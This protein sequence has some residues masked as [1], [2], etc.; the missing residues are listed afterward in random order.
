MDGHL[1]SAVINTVRSIGVLEGDVSS[2]GFLKYLSVRV[3]DV[4]GGDGQLKSLL[5]RV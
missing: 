3:Q 1:V 5:V 2:R 4:A